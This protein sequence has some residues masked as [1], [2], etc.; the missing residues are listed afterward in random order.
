MDTFARMLTP[1]NWI[2]LGIALLTLAIAITGLAQYRWTRLAHMQ[3]HT[4]AIKSELITPKSATPG[5]VSI[6]NS[7]LGPAFIQAINLY[8]EGELVEG[9]LSEAFEDVFNQLANRQGPPIQTV[10]PYAYQQDY[11]VSKDE[12]IILVEFDFIGQPDGEGFNAE[13]ERQQVQLEIVYKDIFGRK[14][15]SIDP[16]PGKEL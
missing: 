12:K 11:A 2:A 8:R 10:Q 1:E 15:V 14:H 16:R 7:G 13:L 4:P 3:A 9:I 6:T 5:S